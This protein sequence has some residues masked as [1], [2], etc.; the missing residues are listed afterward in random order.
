MDHS[1][2]DGD[3]PAAA[4]PR[5]PRPAPLPRIDLNAPTL[6]PPAPR[7]DD[8]P[9]ARGRR[10]TPPGVRVSDP[11]GS[12]PAASKT[13]RE[14]SWVKRPEVMYRRIDAMLRAGDYDGVCR[15]LD[16]RAEVA[17]LPYELELARSVA[18]RERRRSLSVAG[19]GTVLPLLV[20]TWCLGM[21]LGWALRH[22]DLLVF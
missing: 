16:R 3:E 13:G 11:G 21:A 2:G 12:E 8:T 14:D 1:D 10:S 4:L 19:S 22:L 17:S 15:L 5:I 7:D 9:I 6:P 18:H 20:A